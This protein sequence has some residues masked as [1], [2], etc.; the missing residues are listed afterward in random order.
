MIFTTRGIMDVDE[1]LI[2]YFRMTTNLKNYIPDCEKI[3]NEFRDLVEGHFEHDLCNK[4]FN[5]EDRFS[6]SVTLENRNKS[7]ISIFERLGGP[8]PN[9]VFD[10]TFEKMQKLHVKAFQ[11]EL[12]ELRKKL[13]KQ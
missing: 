10:Y 3:R 1:F 5:G 13:E 9:N 6:D 8:I 7:W 2:T 12:L 11:P 4:F